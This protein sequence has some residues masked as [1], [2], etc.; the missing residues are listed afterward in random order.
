MVI[1]EALVEGR[2]EAP[3]HLAR[4][5][6]GLYVEPWAGWFYRRLE[7]NKSLIPL[8]GVDCKP[9]LVRGEKESF[10][11]WLSQGVREGGLPF[12]QTTG[13]VSWPSFTL[14]N[15]LEVEKGKGSD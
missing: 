4:T 12:P 3:K 1:H 11:S 13:S 7:T 6:N 5:V 2:L 14:D 9:V 8:L 10:L 15:L